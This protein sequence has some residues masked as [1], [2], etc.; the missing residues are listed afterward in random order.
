MDQ[1]NLTNEKIKQRFTS[2][3]ELVGY[4]I[5]LADNMSK[6]GRGGKLSLE[7]QNL[8]INVIDEIN[9]GMDK[10]EDIPKDL[11]KE[12]EFAPRDFQEN[13]GKTTEKKRARK[14][15]AD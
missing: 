9:A 5:R 8:A 15:F 4:A 13:R 1:E 7:S 10:F 6:T 3:F 2:Q 14:I 12:P 11:P